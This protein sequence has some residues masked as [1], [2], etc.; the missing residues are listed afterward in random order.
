MKKLGL[1]LL[2]MC[3]VL[4]TNAQ[5]NCEVKETFK[6]PPTPYFSLGYSVSNTN[7]IETGTY[8][9]FEAGMS[10]T[11][12]SVGAVIG[13]G[14]MNLFQKNDN[15]FFY[16]LKVSPFVPL[17]PRINLYVPLG[18]GAYFGT[19]TMFIEHGAGFSFD[20]KYITPWVQYSQWDGV[21]YIS[22][23]ISKSF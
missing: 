7:D 8:A 6:T 11:H 19:S 12:F 2:L 22:V 20:T 9:S 1:I 3:T 16:E 15:N 18:V 14:D 21:N 17:S 13:K 23:G 4:F 10:F 5:A